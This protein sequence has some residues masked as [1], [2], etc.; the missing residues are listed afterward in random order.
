MKLVK[1]YTL[2]LA[3]TLTCYANGIN[4]NPLSVNLSPSNKEGNIEVN[5]P[6]ADEQSVALNLLKVQNDA[7]KN[8]TKIVPFETQDIELTNSDG[9]P[10]Q[11]LSNQ[12]S[13]K[14]SFTVKFK[15][16]FPKAMEKYYVRVTSKPAGDSPVKLSAGYD[17]LLRVGPDADPKEGA[18]AAAKPADK[19]AAAPAKPADKPAKGGKKH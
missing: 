10:I 15:G 14:A 4:V 11:E 3:G 17:V 6:S 8:A 7:E 2:L 5:F 16:E 12:G 19:P 18:A 9:K 1:L 13:K